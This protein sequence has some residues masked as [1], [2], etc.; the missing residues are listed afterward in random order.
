GTTGNVS[1]SRPGMMDFAGRAKFDAWKSVEGLSKEDAQKKYVDLVQSLL[2]ADPAAS[3]GD[4]GASAAGNTGVPGLQ[5]T[6]EDQLFRITLNRP[7]K[8][9]AITW[10]MYEAIIEALGE[11]NK[12]RT[13]KMTVFT[14]IG[15]YYC[16]GN[17]L[18]NFVIKSPEELK[19][20]AERGEKLFHRYVTAY[21]DHNKP[22]VALVNGPAI[23]ISVT[24]LALFDLVLA[25][26]KAT[27]HTPFTSLGQSAEGC[28]TYTFPPLMGASK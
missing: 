8:F 17:D 26:D 23:G 22:L 27:F 15:D 12:D 21:I 1:G 2:K 7:T 4:S 25:S 19:P 10:E 9:N 16:S 20:M 18:S 3:A 14:G 24:L 11:A 13:T 6:K 28:S 5:I